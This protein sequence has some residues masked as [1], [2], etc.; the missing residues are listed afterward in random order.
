MSSQPTNPDRLETFKTGSGSNGGALG[1]LK[2][3]KISTRL[4]SG[5]S[6]IAVLGFAT[7]L[8]GLQ[9]IA[10]INT[11]LNNI[12]D[13]TAPTVETSGDLIA[14]VWE[15]NKVA[16]EIIAVESIER[17]A[18]LAE[19]FEGLAGEY[20]TT[21]AEL[22][23]LVDDPDLLDELQIAQKEHAEFLQSS[24]GMFAAHRTMLE[25]EDKGKRL[26][27]EFDQAGAELITAL[28]EFAEENEAEM[29][30]AEEEGD[31]LTRRGASAAQL[32]DILGRLFEE[33]YP[34]VE[35]A[36]KLQRIVMEMQDT[37]G[38]YLAEETPENLPAIQA[39]F[40]DLHDSTKPHVDV[41][42]RLA[43]TE[44]DKSD[45]ENLQR[46]FA[47]WITF[48]TENERLFD[49]HRD[50]LQAEQE[51]KQ[52]TETLESDADRVAAALDA[53]VNAADALSDGADD[54]ASEV[55]TAAKVM[56]A[57][58]LAISVLLSGGLIV[59]VIATV[60]R[61]IT[62]MT[63]AM[64]VLA[65]GD[66]TVEIPA[67][68]QKDEVG[69]MAE[70]VQFFKD[71]LIESER[72]T[73]EQAEKVE[74]ARAE[75]MQSLAQDLDAAVTQ[76]LQGVS[77]AAEE[78]RT[79]AQ[80]MSSIAEETKVQATSASSASTEA[81][82][83]VQTV[84]AASEELS[85]SIREIAR[86]VEQS[87]NISKRAVGQAS[88]TQDT[89]RQLASAAERIGEVVSLISDIAEQT[90]LLALN[91]TI[92][93]ARAGEA[94]KGFAVVASEVKNLATQTAKA[95]EEIGQQIAEIQGA[96]G[97]AVQAIEGI[98]TTVEEISAIAGSIAAAV[99]EQN[100]ATGE[101][102]RNVQEAATGTSEVTQT[103]GG[104]NEGA[105]ETS[106]SASQVLAAVGELS[107]QTDGL[108]SEVDG[109]LKRMTAA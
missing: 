62:A 51:A 8:V 79:T 30:N 60:T 47:T 102:A 61:P 52:L 71:S 35:A 90:N 99:D 41:L 84:A 81:S 67:V 16:E 59:V 24:E 39:N 20:K 58:M 23:E 9:Y 14:N 73:A 43:E 91:A 87:E 75:L 12:T 65:D 106:R 53:V 7:G 34:V 6:A 49:T 97:G 55:V 86:Q 44:E 107:R 40:L 32:N 108:R 68:G 100:S 28:D 70:A 105:D 17:A 74:R 94:G 72:M 101:I 92:E 38:E 36:L 85:G 76:V 33:D 13:T 3:V 83:N 80:S 15:A 21:Y 37:A 96:T 45:A 88:E 29:A 25:E 1:W 69:E 82:A 22:S 78:M 18:R 63:T 50:M 48:A 19:E 98:A 42:V 31:V 54:A 57:T 64:R 77:G 4:I 104:V 109:F 56:I 103:L 95:T 10:Q 93:A 11:T 27:N 46:L 26:L 66:K 89:V 5:F 2:N